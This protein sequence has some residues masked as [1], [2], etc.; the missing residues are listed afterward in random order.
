MADKT[1]WTDV[2]AVLDD[3]A[4]PAEQKTKLIG[5][6]MRTHPAPPPWS[7]DQEPEEIKQKRK[8]A[9]KYAAS[10]N[11]VPFL[12]SDDVDSVYGEAKKAG[13]QASFTQNEETKAVDEGGKKLDG[14][15]E[16]TA[17]GAGTKTSDEIFDAAAPALKVFQTFGSLLAKVPE[18]C[19][20]TSRALDFEKDIKKPFDEQRGIS[21]KNF[22]DDAAHFKTGSKTVEKA[23]QD[24]G[25]QLNTLYG[26]WTGKA[27]DA[28]SENYN[29]KILPKAKKLSQTLNN[30]SEATLHTTATVFKLCKGKADTVVD[31][32]KEVVGKAD[33]AMAQKVIAIAAGEKSGKEDLGAIAGWMD[34]NF[35]SNLVQQLNNDGC[36]DDDEFKKAGQD[37]AKQWIQNQFIPE[38]WTIIYEGFAKS[39]KE[40]KDFVNQAYDE[41][42]KVMGKVKNEFEGAGDKGGAGGAGGTGGG[43]GGG[44]GPDF[45]G[46]QGG[47]GGGPGGSGTGGPGGGPGD[48]PGGSGKG[49]DFTGGTGGGPGGGPEGGS[50][51]GPGA[52]GSGP[53]GGGTGPTGDVK[54]PPVPDVKIPESGSGSPGGSGGGPGGGLGGGPD[55]NK[56]Q[57]SPSGST[58]PPSNGDE[59]KAAA[60]EA[61]KQAAAAAENAKKQAS[62]ALGKLGDGPAGSDLGG[63]GGS[64]PGGPGPGGGPGGSG[65]TDAAA[66]AKAAAEK[67][68]EEAKKQASDALNKLGD[69]PGGMGDTD[70]KDGDSKDG[71]KAADEAKKKASDALDKLGDELSGEDK[72]TGDKPG[73]DGDKAEDGERETLKVKQGDTTFE[74]TEPDKDGEME[75]KVGDGSGP[76]KD[77]KL[78]WTGEGDE[79]KLGSTPDSDDG[80]PDKDGVHRPGPDGKIHIQDGDV[81]ITAERPDGP[82]GPTVVTVDDGTGKPTTYTLGEDK[83]A[84]DKAAHPATPVT[85]TAQPDSKPAFTPH[86]GGGGTVPDGIGVPAGDT[87][88]GGGGGG[89]SAQSMP[90]ETASPATGQSLSEGLHTGGGGTQQPQPVASGAPPA[91]M[92]GP[93]GQSFGGGAMPPMGMGAGGGGGQGGDQER[94]N[95]AYRIEGEVFD[96]INEPTGRISGSLLD[97]E[98]Q[99]VTRKR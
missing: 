57:T 66:E 36:C 92:G 22:V 5:S 52:G 89:A 1:T 59:Q 62:E 9:E 34:V 88:G 14:A 20:G 23:I 94:T 96:Q 67:A 44:Q 80:K 56:D 10:Y 84:T 4:V 68:G 85:G 46:G 47:P 64:G 27:A 86:H 58:P 19:R 91:P 51:G 37:L 79:S 21:F 18:D 70:A 95:R 54:P 99:S 15:K 77:F 3:P 25:S 29:E 60:E 43:P 16:P 90:F 28:S 41:L 81:K 78:D 55:A 33:F 83:P 76:A 40:T 30:A 32:Y 49:P 65:N 97:D 12:A 73:E 35:G 13:D 74:M 82:S 98:D 61:K 48:G 26:T 71:E 38:M 42:D 45:T 7:A 8:E 87:S 72:L 50:G 24:T 75:I 53:G 11:A 31:L 39:C 17:E 2:K 6:W 69:A 63:S 93:S